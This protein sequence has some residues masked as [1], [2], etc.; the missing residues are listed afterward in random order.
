MTQAGVLLV[1]AEE[2]LLFSRQSAAAAVDLS[3]RQIDYRIASGE[4]DTVRKGRR[5]LIPRDSLLKFSRCSAQ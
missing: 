4:I 2:K 3:V 1:Q 5:V